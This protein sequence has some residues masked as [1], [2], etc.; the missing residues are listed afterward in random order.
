MTLLTALPIRALRKP[1][2]ALATVTLLLAVTPAPADDSAAPKPTPVPMVAPRDATIPG[3]PEG[4]LIQYGR[5]LLTDT[6]RLL[7]DKVGSSMNCTSCHLG[8]G[9]VAYGSPFVGISH[10]FPQYNPRAGRDVTLQ[11]RVNGCMQRSMNGTPLAS[12][13][14]EMKAIIAYME[15]LS[16]DV[17]SHGQVEGMGIGDVNKKLTPDPVNGQRVY[18]AQCASCHGA[19]GEG[20][21]DAAGETI[22]PPLWGEHAFNIG[23][24]MARLFKAATFVKQN[25]PIG[26]RLDGRLGQG[27]VLSDQEALDVAA[28]FT[29]QPRPDFAGKDRDWPKGGKPK[30]ARY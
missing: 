15:W 1:A 25:M 14:H 29:Q 9:K 30:D 3:G 16:K 24:G 10:R 5:R 6:K 28:Y 12:D 23:A 17:P 22:F 2:L 18:V 11:E 8:E 13:S 21:K 20:M 26:I 19:N 4:E 27:Q 7:P